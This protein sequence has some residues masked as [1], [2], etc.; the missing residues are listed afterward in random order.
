MPSAYTLISSN[1]LA[2]SAGTITFSSIPATYTDLVLL[3]SIR[4]DQAGL[5]NGTANLTLNGDTASNYSATNFTSFI[6][7]RNSGRSSSATSVAIG[8]G[9]L[10][11][12]GHLSN[13]FGTL[14]LYIPNYLVSANKPLRLFSASENNV[15]NVYMSGQA[16]LWR[17]TAAITSITFTCGGN[18]V[19]GSS[20]YLYG[21][22]NS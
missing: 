19:P 20:F 8:S 17:N 2:S 18:F 9:A 3:S 7:G 10:N 5:D 1:V 22:K 14:E 12:A 13:T 15:T 11:S 21:I 4:T 6:S 16:I